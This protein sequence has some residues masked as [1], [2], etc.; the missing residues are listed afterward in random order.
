MWPQWQPKSKGR[1]V[2]SGS[3]AP[4]R[5][6]AE[7]LARAEG[8]R[9]VVLVEGISD[10]AALEALAV[11]QGRDLASERVV[12]VPVGGAH[13][14]PTHLR[15]LGPRGAGLALAGLCDE[16]E[17]HYLRRS[18]SRT[19]VGAPRDREDLAALGFFVCVTDLED[20]VVRA[21]GHELIEGV[22]EAH[23]DLSSLRT[24]Q[25]QPDW[26]D[27][28]FT[29]Q[30]RRFLGAGSRRKARYAEHLITAM[31]LDA[32][33]APLVAVLDHTR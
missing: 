32:V 31:P 2:E 15:L 4:Q 24:L 9:S 27:R 5:A 7:A 19:G 8:A 14:M 26:R 22:L 11:R 29:A 12:V 10:Q 17:E 13:A 21:A 23:G 3:G 6:T 25:Q 18:L 20:E 33:P 28:E 16:A 1:D 30:V